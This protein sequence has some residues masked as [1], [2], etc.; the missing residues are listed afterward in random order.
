MD[1]QHWKADLE[2]E[3]FQEMPEQDGRITDSAD[4]KDA[5]KSEN[6]VV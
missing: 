3:H 5:A 4:W 6:Q 2:L 1:N